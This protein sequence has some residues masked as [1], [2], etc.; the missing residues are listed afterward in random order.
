MLEYL[1]V[2]LALRREGI[3]ALIAVFGSSRIRDP[4]DDAVPAPAGEWSRFYTE[5]RD[6]GRLAGTELYDGSH[7]ALIV[8]GGGPGIMEAASRGAFDAGA[9]TVGLNITL[10]HEQMPNSY[11]TPELTFQFRYF[12]LRKM[13]FLSRAVALV[14]FPGGFGT[15]DELFETLTLMQSGKMSVIP[16]VLVGSGFW[17]HLFP[18]EFLATNGFVAEADRELCC[19]V[20]SGAEAWRAIQ[21]FYARRPL[22]VR[23]GPFVD[24]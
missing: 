9:R 10:E 5:A 24:H 11:L 15:T 8:T 22:A 18:I 17:Q 20:D 14:L 6:L 7:R 13:H 12:G 23:P 4:E 19:V 16:V 2:D 1:K 3:D 21:A